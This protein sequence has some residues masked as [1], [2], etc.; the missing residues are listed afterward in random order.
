M[1][2]RNFISI[3]IYM[4]V[5]LSK[6]SFLSYLIQKKRDIFEFTIIFMEDQ[7]CLLQYAEKTTCNISRVY[8]NICFDL[9]INKTY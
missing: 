8:I 4:F 6:S 5:N 9:S 7:A 3:F 2:E 1:N